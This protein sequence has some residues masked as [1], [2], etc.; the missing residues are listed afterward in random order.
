VRHHCEDAT[1]TPTLGAL[2]SMTI[3]QTPPI[4]A[5]NPQA[6]LRSVAAPPRPGRRLPAAGWWLLAGLVVCA[7]LLAVR[8]GWPAY[9][10]ARLLGAILSVGGQ[11]RL[12]EAR[13]VPKWL[14][15]RVEAGSLQG[16]DTLAQV[17]LDGTSIDDAWLQ[18]LAGAWDVRELSLADTRVTDA[19]MAR[20][21]EFSQLHSLNLMGTNVGDDG[22]AHLR[23]LTG[24]TM[25]ALGYS[26][27][28]DAG[29]AHVGHMTRLEYLGLRG[30]RITGT[31]LAQ[32]AGL[33]SL[34]EL[35]LGESRVTDADVRHIAAIPNLTSLLIHD[36]PLTETG[37][38][39]L[40]D[41][42]PFLMH[43]DVS[44][45]QISADGIDDLKRLRPGLS[46]SVRVEEQDGSGF[47]VG[48]PEDI[49]GALPEQ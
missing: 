44:R 30:T 15:L 49:N 22:L 32:L 16:F 28:T 39:T 46:I 10:Q 20:I 47:S 14:R 24:L 11:Y 33:T 29:L 23:P 12:I 7:G 34:H 6:D 40:V 17:F 5:T 18:R 35:H 36:A 45:D 26:R 43:L 8:F 41:C 27:V 37:L 13:T 2:I 21:G 4:S 19:G 1:G 48:R 38:R 3:K 31:G 9:R 25:L 42:L